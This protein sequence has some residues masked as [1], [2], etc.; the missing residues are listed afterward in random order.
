MSPVLKANIDILYKKRKYTKEKSEEVLQNKIGRFYLGRH[1]FPLNA[2]F[3]I[4][5]K[6]SMIE[7]ISWIH[8][9]HYS[10]KVR[11]IHGHSVL[12][13]GIWNVEVQSGQV[14]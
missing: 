6:L 9:L 8:T 7:T 13:I 12:F 3:N 2:S 11:Q 14:M 10:K 5:I 1:R 4:A